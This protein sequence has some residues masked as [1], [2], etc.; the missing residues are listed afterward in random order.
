M[1]SVIEAQNSSLIHNFHS[2]NNNTDASWHLKLRKDI[3]INKF[4]NFE[5][6]LDL[7]EYRTLVA[8]LTAKCNNHY[9]T[10]FLYK[11]CLIKN[12]FANLI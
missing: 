4:P 11:S 9:T 8:E 12:F 1:E 5:K 6:K 10:K 2:K 3:D 7:T